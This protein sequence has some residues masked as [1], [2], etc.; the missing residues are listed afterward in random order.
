ML[1]FNPVFLVYVA[2]FALSAVAFFLN[3][4]GIEVA[5]LPEHLSSRFPRRLFI[6]F[7]LVMSA[8]LLLLWVG[9]RIIPYAIAGRF[10][11]DLAGETTLV[12]QAFDLGTVVPL[13][14][15]TAILLWRRSAW[16]YLL[17]GISL[18]FGFIMCIT[19]PAWIAVPLVQSG[20]INLVEAAP[21]VLLCL[22]G[23]YIAG[24]F[25]WSVREEKV[26]STREMATL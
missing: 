16:G 13:L 23:L 24:R 8:A 12:T 2:I 18:T 22:V 15:A 17:A 10:P 6:G 7:T 20:Q 3:L 25:F 14:L 9:G 1:A 26:R 5:R 4:R 19:L 21:F 11:D